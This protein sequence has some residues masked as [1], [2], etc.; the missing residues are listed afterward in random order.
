MRKHGEKMN[1]LIKVVAYTPIVL[2]LSGGVY[3]IYLHLVEVLSFIGITI[4]FGFW[5]WCAHKTWNEY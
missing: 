4:A 3:T 2:L 1:K 5:I